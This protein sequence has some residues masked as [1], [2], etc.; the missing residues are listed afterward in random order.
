MT[1]RNE[2]I[3]HKSTGNQLK[4]LT[5]E[6]VSLFKNALFTIRTLAIWRKI[7]NNLGKYKPGYLRD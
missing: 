6:V 2:T 3:Y 7:C 4:L 5:L 1:K